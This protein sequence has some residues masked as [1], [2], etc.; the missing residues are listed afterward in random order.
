[1]VQSR[2]SHTRICVCEHQVLTEFLFL[3]F[4]NVLSLYKFSNAKYIG[5]LHKSSFSLV[6]SAG[7]SLF[8]PFFMASFVVCSN[9]WP[10]NKSI[11]RL[12]QLRVKI[13]YQI[14]FLFYYLHGLQHRIRV[15]FTFKHCVRNV[16][17]FILQILVEVR[18]WEL[19]RWMKLERYQCHIY[20]NSQQKG[21][22][23]WFSPGFQAV[24]QK[25]M[26]ILTYF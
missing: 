5:L 2:S 21:C 25:R 8:S 6:K 3:D 13:W 11:I 18:C 22:L 19:K 10:L 23:C 7:L 16:P 14:Q 20:L 24:F 15:E 4:Q 17:L 12:V 1:M 9:Y 26:F